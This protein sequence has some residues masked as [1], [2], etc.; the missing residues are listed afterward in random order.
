[1]TGCKELEEGGRVSVV[2]VDDIVSGTA[3]VDKD[4]AW[5]E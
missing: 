5:A 1:M 3:D 2:V 4:S